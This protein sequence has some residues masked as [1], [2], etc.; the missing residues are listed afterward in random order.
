MDCNAKSLD[1][2]AQPIRTGT[3]NFTVRSQDVFSSLG[4]LEKKHSAFLKV[5]STKGTMEDQ[6]LTKTDP[7]EEAREESKRSHHS[8]IRPNLGDTQDVDYRQRSRRARD[9]EKKRS[10]CDNSQ[11]STFKRP[12]HRPFHRRGKQDVPDFRKHPEKYTHY[13]LGDVTEGD[14]SERSNSQAA[15]AF[16]E[17]RR[18]Q[19]EK[20]ENALAGLSDEGVMFDA[21]LAACSQGQIEFS[22][23]R[24][25]RHLDSE[26][27]VKDD[28]P[29]TSS[30]T[31]SSLMPNFD[32]VV[33]DEISFKSSDADIENLSDSSK[34]E[35]QE[36]ESSLVASSFKSR[37]TN[38]GKR[39]HIRKKDTSNDNDSD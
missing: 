27:R 15:F 3:D 5:L 29:N 38:R 32:D 14:M 1:Q 4:E 37:K 2:A 26:H 6:G 25:K 24:S 8:R 34:R 19:R 31:Q 30:S 9:E 17:E 11:D 12:Q 22:R 35:F 39:N 36:A 20:E 33:L 23:P 21:E 10:A 28:R 16:L 18:L 13:S 7:D